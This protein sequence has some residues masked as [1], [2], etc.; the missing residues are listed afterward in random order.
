MVLAQTPLPDEPLQNHTLANSGADYKE[1]LEGLWQQF[2]SSVLL[3][4]YDI[5]EAIFVNYV[6]I[7]VV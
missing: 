5:D 2:C 6:H 7:R 1:W 4:T 3:V